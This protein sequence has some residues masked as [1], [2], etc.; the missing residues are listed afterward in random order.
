MNPSSFNNSTASDHPPPQHAR[1]PGPEGDQQQHQLAHD[2]DDHWE[3]SQRLAKT[4]EVKKYEDIELEDKEE[5]FIGPRL[6]RVMT[7]GEFKAMMDKLLGD[8]YD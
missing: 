7:N 4:S 8:K 3:E 5:V 1:L 6:P 2:Q